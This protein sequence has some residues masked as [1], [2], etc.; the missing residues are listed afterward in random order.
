METLI[1]VTTNFTYNN[2]N[3]RLIRILSTNASQTLQDLNYTY[4]SAGN[5]IQI[6]DNVNTASQTFQ[7]D[8]LNR[9]IQASNVNYGTKIYSY[10]S[11]GNI[12]SKD[13]KT[14]FTRRN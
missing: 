4:D 2:L 8:H 12:L 6:T 11:I 13:G 10:D 9:L 1:G 7:Y 5:I 14:Y 3:L